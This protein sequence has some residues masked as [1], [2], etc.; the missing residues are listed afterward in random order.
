MDPGCHTVHSMSRCPSILWSFN[1]SNTWSTTAW[2]GS[3]CTPGLTDPLWAGCAR[4]KGKWSVWSLPIPLYELK[5]EKRQHSN[6]RSRFDCK[7][8][9]ILFPTQHTEEIWRR[10]QHPLAQRHKLLQRSELSEFGEIWLNE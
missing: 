3:R 9:H 4:P 5:M 8:V 7:T 2:R 1:L 6:T 10:D